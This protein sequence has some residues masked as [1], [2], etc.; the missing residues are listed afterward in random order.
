MD[1]F[2]I[3]SLRNKMAENFE[4][5]SI[6]INKRKIMEENIVQIENVDKTTLSRFKHIF[7]L[8]HRFE[9]FQNILIQNPADSLFVFISNLTQKIPDKYFEG[10]RNLLSIQ[11]CFSSKIITNRVHFLENCSF[12]GCSSLVYVSIP[13]SVQSLENSLFS[14][15]SSLTSIIIPN[16][17]L[18]IGRECFNECS[19]LISLIIPNSVQSLGE[20]CFWNCSSLK[21]MIIPNS[22]GYIGKGCFSECSSLTFITISNSLQYLEDDCFSDCSSLSSIVISDSI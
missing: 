21:F 12:L 9:D 14:G 1:C 7:S 4:G 13:N 3:K 5:R 19:S 15:C 16:S 22:V 18:Y 20:Y 6:L 8:D 17:V 11:F 2:P 10:L